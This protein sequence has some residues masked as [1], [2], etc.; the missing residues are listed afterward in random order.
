MFNQ[1]HNILFHTKVYIIVLYIY[2][3]IYTILRVVCSYSVSGSSSASSY[4][5][6][7]FAILGKLTLSAW[8]LSMSRN[9][10]STRKDSERT[11]LK[12]RASN[13][14]SLIVGVLASTGRVRTAVTNS[15]SSRIRSSRFRA[16]KY[17][18]VLRC[19]HV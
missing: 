16:S 5:A 19:M 9:T 4:G 10:E 2:V 3:F 11:L 14:G 18:A 1:V 8:L 7:K 6:P 13:K 17:T 15:P 12:P